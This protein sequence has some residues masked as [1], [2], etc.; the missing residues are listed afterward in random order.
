MFKKNFRR[1]MPVLLLLGLSACR[2]TPSLPRMNLAEPGWT[3]HQGQ[4][5]W[6]PRRNAPAIAGDLLLAANPDGRAFVQ[7]SKSPFALVVA[8]NT[9]AAW[10]VEF[11]PEHRRYAGR[12]RPPARLIWLLL[13]GALS[14]RPPP[15]PWSWRSSTNRTWRLE[16]AATGESLRGYFGS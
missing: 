7:F 12:G 1:G 2:S 5:I 16:N 10:Q 11:P 9:D 8:E 14:G 4:A 3:L 13:P 6:R 15:A